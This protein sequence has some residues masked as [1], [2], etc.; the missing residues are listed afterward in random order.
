MMQ[1]QNFERD[2]SRDFN[3]NLKKRTKHILLYRRLFLIIY[4]IIALLAASIAALAIRYD[5]HVWEITS[6]FLDSIW[7][8]APINILTMLIIFW[9]FKLY[10]SLWE[11]ASVTEMQNSVVACFAIG[12]L[13]FAGMQIWPNI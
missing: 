5:F 8:Y 11:Y 6:E 9:V 2:I 7:K 13:Q 4:D 10:H 1:L 12:V 3:M